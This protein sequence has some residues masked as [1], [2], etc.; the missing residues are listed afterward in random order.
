VARLDLALLPIG[1][2]EPRWLMQALHMNPA[3]ATQAHLDREI[4]LSAAE[5]VEASSTD[6]SKRPQRSVKPGSFAVLVV[7]K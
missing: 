1:A 4:Y 5:Y 2:D 7:G 3:E 6:P